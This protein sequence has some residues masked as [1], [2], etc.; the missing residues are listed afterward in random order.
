MSVCVCAEIEDRHMNVLEREE[1]NHLLSPP[2]FWEAPAKRW[3]LL[4]VAPFLV[5]CAENGLWNPS[6]HCI[7]GTQ[8]MYMV[9]STCS[10]ASGPGASEL[11]LGVLQR[12]WNSALNMYQQIGEHHHDSQT[13]PHLPAVSAQQGQRS[14]LIIVFFL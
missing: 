5:R 6:L 12:A 11:I 13:R 9:G 10:T 7:H 3:I 2:L 14:L 1:A 4:I 8:Q